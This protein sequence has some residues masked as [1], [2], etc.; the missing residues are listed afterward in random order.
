MK[1]PT[2]SELY[3]ISAYKLPATYKFPVKVPSTEIMLPAMTFPVVSRTFEAMMTFA[4]GHDPPPL[5]AKNRGPPLAMLSH[6]VYLFFTEI[7][8]KRP[9]IATAPMIIILV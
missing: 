6:I 1:P 7:I 8:I 9:A 3:N 2:L 5:D 4:G